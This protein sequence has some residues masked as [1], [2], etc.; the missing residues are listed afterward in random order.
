MQEQ[1][2]ENWNAKQALQDDILPDRFQC[3]KREDKQTTTLGQGP[4]CVAA[5]SQPARL[6]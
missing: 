6:H 1:S 4:M 3:F 2:D 5:V